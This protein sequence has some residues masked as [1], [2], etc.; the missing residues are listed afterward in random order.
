MELK[1]KLLGVQNGFENYVQFSKYAFSIN[2]LK[3][4]WI[5]ILLT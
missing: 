2:F 5:W 4:L 3:A 1:D